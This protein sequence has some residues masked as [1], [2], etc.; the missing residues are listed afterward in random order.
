[1]LLSWRLVDRRERQRIGRIISSWLVAAT[2]AQRHWRSAARR[3][4]VL[5]PRGFV[6]QTAAW[7]STV[8]CSTRRRH[9]GA[10]QLHLDP[11]PAWTYQGSRSWQRRPATGPNGRDPAAAASTCSR[12]PMATGDGRPE[13]WRHLGD[14]APVVTRPDRRGPSRRTA[15]GSRPHGPSRHRACGPDNFGNVR[16]GRRQPY[17]PNAADA[18]RDGKHRQRASASPAVLS[19][20]GDVSPPGC[21][22]HVVR[23]A[24]G[25]PPRMD[26]RRLGRPEFT[27][28]HMSI[29]PSAP[30]P[31]SAWAVVLAR[32][33][34]AVRSESASYPSRLDGR[35][36]FT[37]VRAVPCPAT[38]RP[39]LGRA[40]RPR[41]QPRSASR[42]DASRRLSV[43]RTC[44]VSSVPSA[45]AVAGAM[46]AVSLRPGKRRRPTG[47][48]RRAETRPAASTDG[49][50][51]SRSPIGAEPA[52]KH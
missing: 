19:G 7:Q 13:P 25:S 36:C 22:W 51:P 45:C 8:S 29:V 11:A 27:G 33:A 35:S 49:V 38:R 12:R 9:H 32:T 17:T 34:A 44:S 48:C 40:R 24:W 43:G 31:P 16:P 5:G 4:T 15:S 30:S 23:G 42:P 50:R 21:C 18:T 52:G 28:S 2:R 6:S 37:F 41:V 3:S 10:R 46:L 26:A 14:L 20:V 39:R 1:M 47:R